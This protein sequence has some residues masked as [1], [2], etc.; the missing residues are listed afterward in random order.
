MIP[1]FD[2]RHSYGE[3]EIAFGPLHVIASYIPT[4]REGSSV[5]SGWMLRADVRKNDGSSF[6]IEGW[7][8]TK[9]EA[10]FN[11]EEVAKRWLQD[12]NHWLEIK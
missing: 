4:R 12:T 5:V 3:E 10:K 8:A 6:V 1:V 11:F 7:G 9:E 2:A